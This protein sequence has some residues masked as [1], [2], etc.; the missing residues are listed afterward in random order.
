MIRAGQGGYVA[1][2]FAARS[3]VAIGW[4][5]IGDLSRA[6]LSKDVRA[7][8]LAAYPDAKPGEVANAV[9]ML[10]K[11]R[12]IISVGD[13]VISYDRAAREYLVGKV[14]GE[15][16]FR[17]GVVTD[18]PHVRSVTWSGRV[19]RDQLRVS[20]RNTLGSTLTLFSLSPEVWDDIALRLESSGR[21]VLEVA[22]EKEDRR[23]SP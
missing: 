8:Y 13:H 2:E 19:S 20:T 7:A 15:Y 11:F 12:T 10:H 5:E 6:S 1:D 22:E 9:A 23:K 14:L 18:H 17:P 3:C 21:Q 16:T 4:A